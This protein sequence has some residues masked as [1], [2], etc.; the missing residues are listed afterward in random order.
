MLESFQPFITIFNRALHYTS[1]YKT[2]NSTKE[3]PS[4]TKV[5]VKRA[6]P[7]I[8]CFLLMLQLWYIMLN[9]LGQASI[10]EK[11]T[12]LKNT[13]PETEILRNILVLGADDLM[14]G[15]VARNH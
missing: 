8:W 5:N 3:F 12:T 6:A 10:R 1:V 4:S 15:T 11:A 13:P 14:L 7:V 9:N 2:V